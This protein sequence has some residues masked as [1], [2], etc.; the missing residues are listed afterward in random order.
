MDISLQEPIRIINKNDKPAHRVK[1]IQHGNLY[2]LDDYITM[3]SDTYI[4]LYLGGFDVPVFV[5]RNANC[6][7]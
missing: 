4:F 6:A 3:T 1:F 2:I 5:G 7:C